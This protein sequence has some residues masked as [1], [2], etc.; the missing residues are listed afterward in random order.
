VGA[1]SIVNDERNQLGA[2]YYYL[3]DEPL[4]VLAWPSLEH[5]S[6]DLT[7]PLTD[8]ALGPI[9]YVTICENPAQHLAQYTQVEPLGRFVAPSGPTSV[10]S[11]YAFRLEKPRG[12]IT[13]AA[14]CG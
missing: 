2:L 3:R 8:A 1:A 12:P 13:P 7:R 4:Q 9:L 14:M 10:R 11:F 5:V 6:F